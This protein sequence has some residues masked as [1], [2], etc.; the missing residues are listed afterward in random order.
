VSA[1]PASLRVVEPIGAGAVGPVAGNPPVVSPAT[2]FPRLADTG[3][4]VLE[5]LLTPKAARQLGAELTARQR[6]DRLEPDPGIAGAWHAYADP[7]FQVLLL[8][9]QPILE[10]IVAAAL[11][12]TYSFAR[13]YLRGHTLPPH[14][15]RD[16]CEVSVTLALGT[17]GDAVW[18][19]FAEFGGTVY[20]AHLGPGDGLLYL[21]CDC[22]HWRG[23]L[24]AAW[25][26][27]VF[28]HY[29]FQNGARAHF[30]HDESPLG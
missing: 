16:A 7:I 28:L 4:V 30:R 13:V 1:R 22:T 23:P 11:H 15:D 18:P 14:V 17:D 21:G 27:H 12:P 24:D 9:A 10:Q 20:E 2:A 25:S 19:F 8:R 6:S 3:L 29:V 26:A 5:Q